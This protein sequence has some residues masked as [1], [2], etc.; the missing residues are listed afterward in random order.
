MDGSSTCPFL[1]NFTNPAAL[2]KKAQNGS[3]EV[4]SYSMVREYNA[5][6]R[7]VDRFD[8]LKGWLEVHRKC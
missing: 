4:E 8:I 7:Y 3:V 5:H 2:P 1:G 6:M